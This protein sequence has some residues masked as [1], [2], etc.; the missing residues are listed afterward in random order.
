MYST[1]APYP[2]DLLK[3]PP[4]L[5]LQIWFSPALHGTNWRKTPVVGE[6]CN[7]CSQAYVSSNIAC[8]IAMAA[9]HCSSR[10]YGEFGRSVG[11]S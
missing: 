2:K 7:P 11:V 1:S 10:G 6:V 9:I 5:S 3:L 8:Q 4:L